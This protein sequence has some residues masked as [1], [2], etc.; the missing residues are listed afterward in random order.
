MK[1]RNRIFHSAKIANNL[2]KN[3]RLGTYSIK[4]RIA[5]SVWRSGLK[6]DNDLEK[7]T[8]KFNTIC[9][10]MKLVT[11]NLKDYTERVCYSLQVKELIVKRYT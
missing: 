1:C 6:S 4:N 11:P 8:Q 3:R 5:P 7:H 10:A 9:E 2:Q